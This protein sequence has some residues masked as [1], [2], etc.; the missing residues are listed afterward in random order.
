MK[1]IIIVLILISIA[2]LFIAWLGYSVSRIQP[3][4]ATQPSDAYPP[5][6][7]A[8]RLGFN[9]I[10][11]FIRDFKEEIVAAGTLFI[12]VFTIVL[13]FATG[14]LYVA[15]RDLVRGADKTAREQLRAYI[16]ASP[17]NVFNLK[18]GARLE[19][20]ILVNN[21]GQ[22]PGNEVT[23]WAGM[24][25]SKPLASDELV[26]L[27]RGEREEGSLVAMPQAPHVMI[28][29]LDA[30][31]ATLSDQIIRGDQRIYVF[32]RIEYKDI[33]EQPRA[34]DFCFVYYGETDDF[35]KNG[36]PGFNST[37]AKYCDKHNSAR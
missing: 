10:I 5:F 26:K 13:A 37:Q 34:S 30:P 4:Q 7:E 22:T 25:I 14:F 12:A 24:K 1:I 32:G 35:P 8:L 2:L 16:Q 9:R 20:R 29:G 11:I 33:F 3:A 21:S 15:T 6:H 23:R 18:S 31:D 28:R 17:G 19:A 27:G 36:G